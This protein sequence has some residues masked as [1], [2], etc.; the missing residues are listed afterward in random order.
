MLLDEDAPVQAAPARRSWSGVPWAI[1]VVGVALGAFGLYRFTSAGTGTSSLISFNVPI[2]GGGGGEA[3][4]A[5]SPD[6]QN[7]AIA[8]PE[9]GQIHLWVR[10]LDG[11][12]ARLLP[13]A[14][15]AR[16]PFWSPDGKQIGFFADGKLKKV[17]LAG[18][19]PTVVADVGLAVNGGT[20]GSQRVIVFATDNDLYKVEETGGNPVPLAR[21][22]GS[23]AQSGVPAGWAA[24][25][26][27]E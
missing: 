11:L 18:G 2:P 22:A 5:L 1:A 27:C 19:D 21:K 7:L 12:E 9:K 16:Y 15:G 4:F 8:S 20:W 6:G 26:L 23:C 3:M 13:G 25:S 10:P 14:E 24:F 17:S